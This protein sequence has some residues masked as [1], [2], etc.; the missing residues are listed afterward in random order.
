[1]ADHREGCSKDITLENVTCLYK[2][3]EVVPIFADKVAKEH[4][5]H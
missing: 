2:F 1:M 5:I 3:T 4:P